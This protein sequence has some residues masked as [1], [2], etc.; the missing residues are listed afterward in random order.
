MSGNHILPP[1]AAPE[2]PSPAR[3]A[4]AD[5]RQGAMRVWPAA[6]TSECGKRLFLERAARDAEIPDARAG[7]S[8]RGVGPGNDGVEPDAHVAAL[9]PLKIPRAEE[10]QTAPGYNFTGMHTDHGKSPKTRHGNKVATQAQLPPLP[11]AFRRS[12]VSTFR[13]VWGSPLLP[14]PPPVQSLR[15]H[16]GEK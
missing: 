6:G 7:K 12:D 2:Y 11:P 15:F 5:G 3:V 10:V 8:S 13:R 1:R 9:S 14:C 4:G 16:P